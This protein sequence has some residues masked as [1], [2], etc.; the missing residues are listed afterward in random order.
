MYVDQYS[1]YVSHDP[2]EIICKKKIYYYYE[3]SLS[4]FVA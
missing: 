2:A 4:F 3:Q 1:H